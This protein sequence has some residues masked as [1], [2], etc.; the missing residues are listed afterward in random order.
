MV[1]VAV[2]V[3]WDDKE[4]EYIEAFKDWKTAKKFI[5]EAEGIDIE[6]DDETIEIDDQRVLILEETAVKE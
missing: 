6:E 3:N 1:V 4:I 5:K 2:F